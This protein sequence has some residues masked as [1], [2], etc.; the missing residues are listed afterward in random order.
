MFRGQG[1][2]SVIRGWKEV[3]ITIFITQGFSI[4]TGP[5]KSFRLFLMNNQSELR[6][7]IKGL[8]AEPVRKSYCTTGKGN[9]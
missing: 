8:I 4:T 3:K 5:K 1:K 9:F 6:T 2:V 7:V